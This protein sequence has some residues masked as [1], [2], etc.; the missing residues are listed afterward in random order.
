MGHLGASLFG[1]ST[2]ASLTRGLRG[3]T[4]QALPLWSKEMP[5]PRKGALPVTTAAGA[6]AVY[7]PTCVSRVMGA[8][9]GEPDEVTLMGA[10][11]N[12][13]ERAGVK[14][15]VPQD[16]EGVCCGV[17]FSSKG[18]DPA[19]HEAIN[20]AIE[21]F[22]KWTGEGAI[23]VVVDTSPCSHGL[24][25]ARPYLTAENQARFDRLRIIDSI[26]FANDSLLPRLTVMR[27]VHSVV[28]HPVCSVTKMGLTNKLVS[29]AAACSDQV[30]VPQNAGCCAFAGDRGF[31][32]PELTAAATKPEAVEVLE[33]NFDG[34]YSSSRT[35]EVGMTRA[36]GKIYRSFLH[37]LDFAT[38]P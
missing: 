37:L 5:R 9:P 25:T 22:W 38:K 4:G 35:C 26:E 33:G 1:H 27:K 3:M 18:F 23:P 20:H 34:H 12:V 6:A 8:L 13:A 30:T 14:L 2:M 7:F 31:L 24:L 36:T 21:R 15:Y 28:L 16:A 29:V 17:P 10:L 32:F 19:H 11:L